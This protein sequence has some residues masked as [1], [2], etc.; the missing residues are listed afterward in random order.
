MLRLPQNLDLALK[1]SAVLD[2]DARRDEVTHHLS[3]FVNLD[4]LPHGDIPL[5]GT[6]DDHARGLDSRFYLALGPNGHTVPLHVDR[7]FELPGD[8]QVFASREFP[9]DH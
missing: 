8:R 4:P 9:F 7:A 2:G 5:H 3:G 1:V 6:V